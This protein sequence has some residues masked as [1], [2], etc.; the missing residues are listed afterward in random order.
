VDKFNAEKVALE[1]QLKKYQSTGNKYVVL[2]ARLR[3]KRPNLL[4]TDG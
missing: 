3:R 1:T 2:E 4:V